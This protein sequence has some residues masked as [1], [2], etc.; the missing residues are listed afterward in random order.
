MFTIFLTSSSWSLPK[1]LHGTCPSIICTHNT[2]DV[3]HILTQVATKNLCPMC[4][5]S[6]KSRA[7]KRRHLVCQLNL[8]EWLF[9]SK[10]TS[11]ACAVGPSVITASTDFSFQNLVFWEFIW[12]SSGRNHL[13]INIYHILNPN[14]TK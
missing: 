1:S 5:L 11:V 6:T 10:G 9:I 14:L 8:T 12:I 7:N 13:K 2:S 4:T 3:T